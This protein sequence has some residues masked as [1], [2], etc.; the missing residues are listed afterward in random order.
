MPKLPDQAREIPGMLAF[1][2][3]KPADLAAQLTMSEMFVF[4]LID[5]SEILFHRWQ[6]G[7]SIFFLLTESC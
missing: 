7:K 5:K 1:F 2:T 6:S 3:F 4:R